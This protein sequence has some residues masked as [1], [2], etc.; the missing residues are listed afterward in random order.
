MSQPVMKQDAI[1]LAGTVGRVTIGAGSDEAEDLGYATSIA[2]VAQ[3]GK[4][5]Y[6]WTPAASMGYIP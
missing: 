6:G 5:R 2:M 3:T 4:E 1:N